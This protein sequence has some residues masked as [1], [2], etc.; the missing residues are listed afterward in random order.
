MEFTSSEPVP[1]RRTVPELLSDRSAVSLILANLLTIVLA[2]WQ[3]W[4]LAPLLWIYW[5]QSVVI[6]IFNIARILCLREFST[7]GFRIN[8]RPVQPTRSTKIRTALFFACHYGLF[9]LVYLGF[10]GT[11]RP[12]QRRDFALVFVCITAFLLNH[13]YSFVRSAESDRRIRRNIG[14]LMMFPYARIIPMHLTILFG[15][16]LAGGT[17][18]LLLFLALKTGADGVMHAV[19]H[20][21]KLS[22]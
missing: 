5:C 14:T 18:T 22:S 15:G 2:V 12:L 11:G 13:A 16:L 8:N 21:Q 3:R 6:G 20:R 10:L 1:T 9:H 17:G 7:R 19:E 4:D